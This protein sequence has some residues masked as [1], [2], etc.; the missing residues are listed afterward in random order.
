MNQTGKIFLLLFCIT[1]SIAAQ[2]RDLGGADFTY[3]AGS[4]NDTDFSRSRVWLNY[5]IKLKKDGAFLVNGLRYSY[6][7]ASFD[8]DFNFSTSELTSFHTLEYTIGYTFPL[9]E[10]WRFTA[11]FSP[12]LSSNLR[13]GIGLR[14]FLFNGGVI[15]IKTTET[16]KKSRLFLGLTFNQ[17][18]GIPAPVPFINYFREINEHWTYTVGF[19]IS[20]TKYFFNEK[21]N[22]LE[23]FVRLDGYFANLS[24]NI[25]VG[26]EQAEAI[27][28][29]QVIIGLGFD[30]Y[31]GE[32]GNIFLK[33]GYTLRNSLRLN[34]DVSEEVFDFDLSNAIF[35]RG[36]FKFNL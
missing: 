10:K 22:S 3:I 1:T 23:A 25:A 14:D 12:T 8:K 11:Q 21:K 19:P 36:G 17:T 28:L 27:S 7:T 6:G 31:T 9:N 33:V 24:N 34:R 29:S 16:P 20:K 5:P 35:I 30:R 4:G 26:S 13:G 18:I 15:F 32:R 2:I